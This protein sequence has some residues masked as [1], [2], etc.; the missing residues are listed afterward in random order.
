MGEDAHPGRPGGIR[1]DEHEPRSGTFGIA[2]HVWGKRLDVRQGAHADP[3]T[4]PHAGR[5]ADD[6]CRHIRRDG[7]MGVSADLGHR[8]DPMPRPPP[9][10]STQRSTGSAMSMLTSS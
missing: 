7:R 5:S 9:V 1:Q 3:P 8:N 4:S 2:A 10:P 6:P